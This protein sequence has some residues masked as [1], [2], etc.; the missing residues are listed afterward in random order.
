MRLIGQSPLN[1]RTTAN[2]SQLNFLKYL[3]NLFKLYD[4]VIYRNKE[5]VPVYCRVW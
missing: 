3:K 1:Q 4:I 5:T 2:L